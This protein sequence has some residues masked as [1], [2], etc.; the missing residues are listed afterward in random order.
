MIK[1]FNTMALPHPLP[2]ANCT[3]RCSRACGCRRRT[4]SPIG[5]KHYEVAKYFS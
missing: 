3:P 2:Y 4:V 1:T 5:E